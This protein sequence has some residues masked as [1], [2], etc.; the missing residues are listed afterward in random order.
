MLAETLTILVLIASRHVRTHTSERPYV[1][2]LCNKAFSRSDNLAQHR[3][4]HDANPDGT[5]FPGEEELE[6]PEEGIDLSEGDVNDSYIPMPGMPS[7]MH[8]DM[9][10]PPP[11]MHMSQMS[12]DHMDPHHMEPHH[13]QPH[14]MQHSMPQ[15]IVSTGAEYQ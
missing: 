4:T 13:M 5:N 1:C 11:H 7:E 12:R 9:G 3:R 10:P 2:P 8:G 14:H 15:G 6:E